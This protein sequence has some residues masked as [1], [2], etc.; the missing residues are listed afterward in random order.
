MDQLDPAYEYRE[1]RAET[2]QEHDRRHEERI[3]LG[4]RKA[5]IAVRIGRLPK[6]LHGHG[7][8]GVGFQHADPAEAL[9]RKG[10][11][12]A[13]LLLHSGAPAIDHIAHVVDHH[14]HQRQRR[15]CPQREFGVHVQHEGD[16]HN[17]EHHEVDRV[18]H[19]RAQVHAHLAHIL[20]DP[21]H[22]VAGA[23]ALVEGAI[24]L[25]VVLEH[26]VLQV[27]LD[28]AAHHDDRLSHQEHE[29][30]LQQGEGEV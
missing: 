14:A 28:Q 8:L 6:A 10:A 1:H 18:H 22:E 24:Q 20:A 30:P 2:D 29:E 23:I 16:A 17:E 26:V 21:V 27:V 4:L 9:L 19:R 25:L 13:L 3:D 12:A 15:Q 5:S 11:Q 7:F